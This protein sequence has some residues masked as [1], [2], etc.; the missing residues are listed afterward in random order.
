MINSDDDILIIKR[1]D[2]RLIQVQDIFDR[3][4]IVDSRMKIPKGEQNFHRLLRVS[5]KERRIIDIIGA[6]LRV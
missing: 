5:Q 6:I 3:S 2:R 4:A 1:I